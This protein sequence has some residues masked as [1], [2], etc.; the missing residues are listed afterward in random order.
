MNSIN[1]IFVGGSVHS[2]KNILWRLLDGHSSMVSNCMHSNLGYFVLNDN[3]K[4]YFLRE[5]PAFLKETYVFIPMCKI[6]YSSGEVASV[7]IG[8]FLYGLYSFSGYR[9]LYSWAKGNSTFLNMK[10]GLNERFP[11]VFDINGFEKTLEQIMFSGERIFTEEE[12]LDVIYSSY[13][14]NLGNKAPSNNLEEKTYFVDT[15][16]NGID[17]LRIVA[18]KVPGA[19]IIIM[20]RDV[21]SL[22]YAN[23]VRIMSYSGEV[24][25]DTV[26][27]KRILFNQ[28]EFEKK[29]SSFNHEAAK[30]QASNKNITL[31]NF[32]DLVLNTEN[33][34]KELVKFIGIGYEPILASP[35]INGEVINS[36]KYQIIG[37]INDDPYRCLNVADMD[38]LKYLLYGFNKQYSILKNISILLRAIKWRM[39]HSLAIKIGQLLKISLPRT[40]YM[41]IKKIYKGKM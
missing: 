28:K 16:A 18:E 39:L 36:D 23:A 14:Q 2:G 33:I 7:D 35:S 8:S 1:K 40:F 22:L 5:K 25:V 17:S 21:E 9:S 4:K 41:K 10:E 27:F 32:N 3:C 6:S 11:F 12:V 24:K 26:A 13:I 19:K 38:L 29:M 37:K 31:L 20:T 15:L 34:M 30:L